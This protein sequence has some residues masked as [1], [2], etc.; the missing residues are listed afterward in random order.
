MRRRSDGELETSPIKETSHQVSGSDA[1]PLPGNQTKSTPVQCL[2]DF[3][4]DQPEIQETN[5]GMTANYSG[6]DNIILPKI[7]T[8]QTEGSF[9][10]DE[11]KNDFYMPMYSTNILK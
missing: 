9:V 11:T 1:E 3:R 8:S 7:T 6:D 10:R 4:E 5:T 2:N